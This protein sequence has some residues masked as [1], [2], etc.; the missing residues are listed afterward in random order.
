[1][2]PPDAIVMRQRFPYISLDDRLAFEARRPDGDSS[3]SPKLLDAAKERLDRIE[4]AFDSQDSRARM[5][6]LQKLHSREVASFIRRQGNGLSRMGRL[7]TR[8]LLEYAEA[9]SIVITE[10][11]A[12]S[13]SA[14]R[15]DTMKLQ[16]LGN[17]EVGHV[18]STPSAE[19][20]QQFHVA[21][22]IAF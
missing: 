15:L 12:D 6:S 14:Q 2:V 21:G 22:Q 20:L 7:P 18:A 9:V 1:Q 11:A 19:E 4:E 17:S 5:L 16:M 10:T 13:E 3:T 8:E